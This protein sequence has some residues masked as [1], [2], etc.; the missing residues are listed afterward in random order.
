VS[1]AFDKP[2]NPTR[3]P[4]LY[5]TVG[6]KDIR[7]K[8][9]GLVAEGHQ[10]AVEWQ[11]TY[12]ELL[13]DARNRLHDLAHFEYTEL[14][15]DPD[16]LDEPAELDLGSAPLE[17]SADEYEMLRREPEAIR[18]QLEYYLRRRQTT[19][20]LLRSLYREGRNDALDLMRRFDALEGSALAAFARLMSF[21]VGTIGVKPT[22]LNYL[23]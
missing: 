20:L 13:S 19:R 6:R 11:H 10:E 8:L 21:E 1:E 3:A 12:E 23:I 15:L 9:R 2:E 7:E 18:G 14:N 4:D 5:E 22:S 16:G 17:A